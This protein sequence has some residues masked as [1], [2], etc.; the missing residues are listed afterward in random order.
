MPA[1]TASIAGPNQYGDHTDV[2]N[3]TN[4][5]VDG[6]DDCVMGYFAVTAYNAAGESGFSEQAA[7]FPRPTLIGTNPATV[8]RGSQ[9]TLVLSGVNFRPGDGVTLTH[10]ALQLDDFAVSSCHEIVLTLSV[11]SDAPLG[12]ADITVTHP[13]GVIGSAAGLLEIVEDATAPEI[14]GVTVADIGATAPSS[15]GPPTRRPTAG[16]SSVSRA[17][18]CTGRWGSPT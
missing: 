15:P 14:D 7:S 10:P 5:L 8:E 1:D 17:T 9:T 6:M 2:G 13:S 16:C 3:T 4:T 18:S 11:D 12:G